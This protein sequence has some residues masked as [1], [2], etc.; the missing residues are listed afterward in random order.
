MSYR[1]NLRPPALHWIALAAA[2]GL[3]FLG[4]APPAAAQSFDCAKA[5]PPIETA[6]CAA[7]DLLGLDAALGRLYAQMIGA[8]QPTDPVKAQQMR[9]EQRQWITRRDQTCAPSAGTPGQLT[10]CLMSA[11]RDRTAA[12]TAVAS[13]A[14]S[15]F[16]PDAPAPAATLSRA[17]LS[18]S[19]DD[20]VLLNV[21]SP[22]RFSI[23]AVSKT[24]VALQLVDMIAGPGDI[25]G[26]AGSHDGRLDLLLDTGTYKIRGFGAKGA[27]GDAALSVEPFQTAQP[28]SRD[29]LRGGQANGDI[30]DL[31]QF[32]FWVLVDASQPLAVEAAGRSLQDLRAWRSG[33][34][35]ADLTPNAAVVE[36]KAGHAMT[37]LRLEGAVAP[38]LYLVTAYGGAA[39]P[40]A[41]GDTS[42]P[43]HIRVGP[44]GVMAGGW[45]EGTIGPLGSVR[46]Q[47]PA[48]ASYIRLQLPDP[49]PAR[50]SASRTGASASTAAIAQN[51]REPVASLT[52]PARGN[53]PLSV[54]V[55]GLEGQKFQLRAL[56]PSSS[57]RVDEAGPHLVSV[58]V[59]GEGG[60]EVP[61]TALLARF[62]R[63]GSA[64]VV[65]S[66]APRIALGQAWRKRFN[67]RGPTSLIFEITGAG[68]VAARTTGP[69]VH[70]TLEP[71]LGA[72][73]PRSD[74]K[75]PLR[76][77]VE[78]GWYILKLDPVANAVGIL[79]LTFGQ[80]GLAVDPIASTPPR[81]SIDFGIQTLDKTAYY[82]I[83]ANSAPS[84]VTGPKAIA[85]PADLTATPLMLQQPAKDAAATQPASPVVPSPIPV[86]PPRTAPAAAPPKQ[87]NAKA[88]PAK[89]AASP[90]PLPP[91]PV[92]VRLA[93]AV[94]GNHT[95]VIPIRVLVDGT[96]AAAE[97]NGR[98]VAITTSGETITKGIRTLTVTIAPADHARTIVLAWT[99]NVPPAPLPAL[100]AP[101]DQTV[102]VAGKPQ[103]FDLARG[104]RRGFRLEVPEGGLFHVETLGRLKTSATIATPFLPKLAEASDN[105]AGHNALLQTYLRA[106]SYRVGVSA[107]DSQGHLGIVA[108]PAPLIDA[109]TLIPEGSARAT[110]AQGSGAVFSLDI[111][112]SGNYRLDL[113]GLDR[114]FTA[115]LEDADGWPLAAPGDLDDVERHFD[116]GRY[117]LVVL[118]QDVDA[119]VVARLRRNEDPAP[120]V[121]HGPHPLPFDSAQ[122]FEWREPQDN[123]APRVPDR[124]EFALQAPAHVT[125]D[126]SDGMI[127]DLLGVDGNS[128][129]I[130]KIVYKRG[131]TGVLQPG[132][133]AVEATALGR[134]D[135]LDYELDLDAA[136]IQPGEARNIDL[137][138]TIP[139]AL[140]TDGVVN[141]TSYGRTDLTG[142]LKD[143]DGHILERLSGRTDDWNIALSRRLS[144][145][146]YQL[147][148]A[149]ANIV[150][151]NA[152]D[153][154]DQPAADDDSSDE[155]SLD[156]PPSDGQASAADSG[157][158]D[159]VEVRFDLPAIADEGVLTMNSNA[160]VAGPQAHLF[161][162]SPVDAGKLL[163]VTAHSPAELAL[164]LE[165]RGVDG[166]WQALSFDRGRAPI[167]AVP[168]DS[169]TGRPWRISVWAVDGGNARIDVA[170]RAVADTPQPLGN[171]RLSP[172]AIEGMPTAIA[173]ASVAAPQKTI[174]DLQGQV[175][176]LIQGST[177]GRP[178][179]STESGTLAPQS[180]RVWFVARDATTPTL[181]LKAIEAADGAFALDLAAGDVALL[182]ASPV[183]AGHLRLWQANSTF[184]QP[185]ISTG[186]A[187][188]IIDGGAIAIGGAG[189]V[190]VWNA[191]GHEPLR[192][193]VA[194]QDAEMQT[195]VAVANHYAVLLPPHSA[196]PLHLPTGAHLF[197]LDLG[198]NLA[199]AFDGG[200]SRPSSIW[201]GPT[202]TTRRLGGKLDGS[203][204]PQYRR[205]RGAGD[206][207]RDA[208][209][210]KSVAGS[211]LHHQ[212]LFRRRRFVGLERH[213]G[214][215][216]SAR[217]R[218]RLGHV[219]RNRRKRRTRHIDRSFDVGRTRHRSWRWSGRRLDRE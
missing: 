22:G 143:A 91:K 156:D 209:I 167:V 134:N 103:F 146:T 153:D 122:K 185:G 4:A 31:Q 41:D 191:G 117:R 97:P 12:L 180:D 166:T 84:L 1:S 56:Q 92:A 150:A 211:G 144:A 72:A 54:D 61:A 216:R 93:P 162:L 63:N 203:D 219:R 121:G 175:S 11:Y 40:W 14:A 78:A 37:R 94:A 47:I 42:L 24:G 197:D 26:D 119:R 147:G 67:L 77:D 107:R 106:G 171:I 25:S 116:R 118:P 38:G 165:R 46:F 55:S 182:P 176:G 5:R 8:I 137:P 135:R 23:R 129:S 68:P 35:L 101:S 86:P 51:S 30:R 136:E 192:L 188:G 57:L 206:A 88:G 36:P 154:G 115:R 80:P 104:G 184:G 109:G 200:D 215:G 27:S 195:S 112:E 99:K 170:A 168:A 29:L 178:L 169:D 172:L 131:F 183:A 151:K 205:C 199:A 73:A 65:A 186:G 181:T 148:L 95:L 127:G 100:G 217:R 124:W 140:A 201:S 53:A 64:S 66:D 69:G 9:I 149:A 32:S 19:A 81:T 108:R 52:V 126:I 145:G 196:Q 49:A 142:V 218:R 70:V 163:L 133:Y 160:Q 152:S 85:L 187:M 75:T 82:Q 114:T 76:W 130:A 212:A 48:P 120:L 128:K 79:D 138:A 50:L 34:D 21:T 113:Y 202:A 10:T 190:R 105:G 193:R 123:K 139:F 102:L 74:G 179:A 20:E 158:D 208:G 173:V 89:P 98:S 71:L 141:L 111:P 157:D 132:R 159:G 110:L 62:D 60:D 6:I 207:R 59:A 13:A 87:A 18:A 214:E 17:S 155:H 45:F 125:L 204:A 43:F 164:S 90:K 33:T 3:A 213:G 39:L 83:F 189:P 16:P 177:P 15:S 7:P 194:A 161:A 2:S 28:T 96:L 198:P 210:G 58:D 44:P 174:V